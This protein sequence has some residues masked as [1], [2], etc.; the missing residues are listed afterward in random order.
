M[1]L[2][3]CEVQNAIDGPGAQCHV[4][5]RRQARRSRIRIRSRSREEARA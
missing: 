1:S 2:W 4:I 3:Q 5:A